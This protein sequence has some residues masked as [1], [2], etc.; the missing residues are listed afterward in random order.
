MPF[1]ERSRVRTGNYVFD[2]VFSH[3]TD[4]VVKA[5]SVNTFNNGL[6]KYWHDRELNLTGNLILKVPEVE[7]IYNLTL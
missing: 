3:T 4:T 2:A 1:R 5:E 6:D 7:V